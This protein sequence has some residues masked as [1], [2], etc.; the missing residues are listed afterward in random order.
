MAKTNREVINSLKQLK[1]DIKI[2]SIADGKI[3]S[4]LLSYFKESFPCQRKF[5]YSFDLILKPVL[6]CILSL[7]FITSSGLGAASM[8]KQSLPGTFLYPIKKVVEKGKVLLTTGN[9]KTVL[10]AEILNNRLSEVKILAK[11]MEKGD[12]ESEMEL[13]E[14]AQNFSNE[15]KVLKNQIQ[16]QI[17]NDN[18]NSNLPF[19]EDKLLDTK[20]LIDSGSLPV[21]D[22]KTIYLNLPTEDLERLLAETKDLLA[23][24]N[25]SLALARLNEAEKLVRDEE[26]A[27]K[28]KQDILEIDNPEQEIEINGGIKT[29]KVPTPVPVPNPTPTPAPVNSSLKPQPGSIGQAL[30]DLKKEQEKEENKDDFKTDIQKETKAKTGIIREK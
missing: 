15:L 2:D 19:P 11:R 25:L 10:R 24:N 30:N 29:I 12:T 23:E 8:A 14:L 16:E 3:Q 20:D 18:T 27:N 7:F 4:D 6:V 17:P 5:N 26:L 21:Q 9:S 13:N 1:N 28:N 22:E